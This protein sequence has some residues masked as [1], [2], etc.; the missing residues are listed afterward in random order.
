MLK[1]ASF[2]KPIY[3]KGTPGIIRPNLVQT[4]FDVVLQWFLHFLGE[5]L[6]S[7]H[8]CT[9]FLHALGASLDHNSMSISPAVVFN[10][11]CEKTTKLYI[12]S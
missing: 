3:F 4:E 2:T 7:M 12:Q 6:P 10:R 9:K 1:E 11:T 5:F 8:S